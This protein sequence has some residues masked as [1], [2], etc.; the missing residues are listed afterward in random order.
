MEEEDIARAIRKMLLLRGL[1]TTVTAA[2]VARVLAG[3]DARKWRHLM[4]PIKEVAAKL[5]ADGEI[6][7]MRKGKA[8]APDKIKGVYR[9][10]RAIAPVPAQADPASAATP[11]PAIA[12]ASDQPAGPREDPP[13]APLQEAPPQEGEAPEPEMPDDG[14]PGKAP[15]EQG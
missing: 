5:A 2:E 9:M 6:V 8:V 3:K 12:E 7:I 4:K 13:E 15:D 14:A 1:G 10:A 11:G